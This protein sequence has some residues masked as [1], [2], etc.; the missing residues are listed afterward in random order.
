MTVC[1]RNGV[2]LNNAIKVAAISAVMSVL[3]ACGDDSSTQGTEPTDSD[4]IAAT[5][6]DLPVCSEK[7]QGAVGYVKD[8]KIAYVCEDGKWVSDGEDSSSSNHCEDASKGCDK[9][10]SSSSKAKSSS[11]KKTSSS[12]LENKAKSSSSVSKT[13][14]S[15]SVKINSSSSKIKSSSSSGTKEG[16]STRDTI[17]VT[18]IKNKS[19]SGVSQKG[20]PAHPAPR[21][22]DGGVGSRRARGTLHDAPGTFGRRL[23]RS[24]RDPRPRF[25][26]GDRR[27]LC[28]VLRRQTDL[29]RKDAPLLLLQSVLYHPGGAPDARPHPGLGDRGRGDRRPREERG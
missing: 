23:R 6:D 28:D 27:P 25:R 18:A 8:K 19:V 20:L 11:S 2:N 21:R 3:A 26:I 4:V 1:K 16:A 13:S 10:I 24:D 9:A 22:A 7:R 15:S 12:S 5:F 14:S 17:S 29:L